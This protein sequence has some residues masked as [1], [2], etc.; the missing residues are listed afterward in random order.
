MQ[1]IATDVSMYQEF[2]RNIGTKRGP[3]RDGLASTPG[4]PIV[5]ALRGY[6][7]H[8]WILK[9]ATGKGEFDFEAQSFHFLC[10]DRGRR[11]G[12]RYTEVD[13]V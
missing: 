2:K 5:P 3:M 9:K 13:T 10:V 12:T 11:R 1:R 4:S 6:Q 8:L 7:V